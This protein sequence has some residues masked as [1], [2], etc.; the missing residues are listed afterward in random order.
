LVLVAA[1]ALAGGCRGKKAPARRDAAPVRPAAGDAVP[2]GWPELADLPRIE[3]IAVIGLPGAGG[4]PLA[5]VVGPVVV[6]DLAIVGTSRLGFVALDWRTGTVAWTRTA[7]A[8]L[9]PP[10]PRDDG[11]LLVSDCERAPLPPT[12]QITVG[13]WRIVS[14]I[15]ADLAAGAVAGDAAAVRDFVGERG[16][17]RWGT[18]DARPVWVRGQRAVALDLDAGRAEPVPPGREAVIARHAGRAWWL[19]LEDDGVLV[20]RDPAGAEAWRTRTTFAAVVGVIPGQ[21]YE[22]PMARAVKLD[23]VSGKGVID[24][25]DV[26][27][28]GSRQGQAGTTV[29]GIAVLAHALRAPGD[30]VLAIRLDATVQHDFV[31]AHDARGRLAWVWPLPER[32]RVDPVGL[33]ITADAVIA[34]H[35]GDRVAILPPVSVSQNPTP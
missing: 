28:T 3:P 22:V 32:P 31:S 10:L 35:D 27:V 24:L 2:Y 19:A 16:P 20:A 5:S 13:C 34:F 9:A 14:P 30:T 21:R 11:V 7:G 18:D 33:A 6:G 4:P 8:H 15:G 1:V 26:E 25:L 29:P 23:G 17:V 12:G